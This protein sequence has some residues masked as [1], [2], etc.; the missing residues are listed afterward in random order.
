MLKTNP[1]SGFGSLASLTLA[2]VIGTHGD[3]GNCQRDR[4][5]RTRH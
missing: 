2:L 5:R 1:A 3:D 4:S